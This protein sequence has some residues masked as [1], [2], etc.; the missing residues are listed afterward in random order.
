MPTQDS[1]T[2]NPTLIDIDGLQTSFVTDGQRNPVI[3]DISF[4]IGRGEVLGIVGESGSGKSVTC[5][6]ITRLLPAKISKID[7]GRVVFDGVDLLQLSEDEMRRYRGGRIAMIFQEPMSALNPVHKCGAQVD[8]MLRMHTAMSRQDRYDKVIRLFEKVQLPQAADVYKAYPHELSGGQ[9]QRIMIAMAI[10][11]EPD[12][13][14]ADEPTTALDVTVQKEIITLLRELREETGMAMIFISHDLGVISEI[15][16]R[17][18]V[19]HK[20]RIVE[21]GLVDKV[22]NEP[23]EAY[24]QGLVACRP[25]LGFRLDR[26]PTVGDFLSDQS[27]TFD[28]YRKDYIVSRADYDARLSKLAQA[29]TLLQVHNLTKVYGGRGGLFSRS[30]GTVAV[31]DVSFD[32]K[33]GETLGLVGESGCGKSTLGKTLLRLLPATKGHVLYEGVD[34]LKLSEREMRR[35]RKA[36]QMIFQDPFSALN[37]RMTVGRAIQEPME[38]HRLHG[39]RKSRKDA[40]VSLLEQVGLQADH[41][42]RYPHQFSGGQRQRICIARTLA[43]EPRFIVCDESVS[44]LD[45]SVQAQVL[46]LLDDLKDQYNLTF[47]FISHDLAVVKHF[48]DRIMVMKSGQV[49]EVGDAESVFNHPQS[50]YTMQLLNS[51]PGRH[52]V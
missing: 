25:P 33:Q 32:I 26:L 45:V 36:V 2:K 7:R 23:Q 29:P 40:V 5:Y 42:H 12:L 47:L 43:V 16:D 8:E 17:V 6:S 15:A 52:L 21:S 38:V 3:Y 11:C 4:S 37:P 9:L 39:S 22:I 20:G 51:N 24:T 18:I 10:A 27:L 34:L 41:Y 46:N 14:I 31:D 30:K 35:K 48:C 44:A 49:V 1:T 13:L 28:T 50:A 19:M